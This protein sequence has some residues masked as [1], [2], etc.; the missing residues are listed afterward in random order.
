MRLQWVFSSLA[1]QHGCTVTPDVSDGQ[2]D[3]EE[4]KLASRL[5]ELAKLHLTGIPSHVFVRFSFK[6]SRVLALK[7]FGG[8]VES[9]EEEEMASSEESDLEWE[10]EDE[11]S[12]EED[13]HWAA[14]LAFYKSGNM[15][16]RADKRKRGT[17]SLTEMSKMYRF[18]RGEKEM[19][20]LREYASSGIAP[21]SRTTRLKELSEAFR[22]VVFDMMD[23]GL[24][25]H[26]T[27]LRTL[28]IRENQKQNLVKNFKASSWWVHHWKRRYGVS[29]RKVTKFVTRK[30]KVDKTKQ[31]EI[32]DKF[33]QEIK[34]YMAANPS[35]V[36]L[37]YDQ[38]GVQK[39][40]RSQRT[41]ARK[42]EKKVEVLASSSS[43]LTH[44]HTLMP[45]I[46]HTGGINKTLFVQTAE[47]SGKFPTKMP[48]VPDNIYLTCGTSHIMG[49]KTMEEFFAHV[50]FKDLP[51]EC[52]LLLDSWG[53]FRKH[54]EITKHFPP[55][56]SI[57]IKNIPA[58]ATSR[59]QPLD[60][61]FN[62]QL[63]VVIRR[64]HDH[65]IIAH[66]DTFSVAKRENSMKIFSQIHWAFCHSR[67][68]PNRVFAFYKC[69]YIDICP[70]RS[71]SYTEVLFGEGTKGFC[72]SYACRA[73]GFVMCVYCEKPYCFLCYFQNMHRCC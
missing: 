63:K 49:Y 35:S 15:S 14:A 60:M 30:H 5:D 39:E 52:L 23:H 29:S 68:I 45:G 33:V 51:Q 4:R 59:I 40:L 65:A 25:L 67:F 31:K 64:I 21:K 13:K 26:D 18:I 62:R 10:G 7:L 73:A 37:N 70:P 20:L 48:P 19:R 61:A 12:T 1:K 22:D 71:P 54:S 9:E 17:R 11:E 3:R 55:G 32:E 44:S 8:D 72:S 58:G 47:P 2:L 16:E 69:G 36:V 43:A 56:H 24:P 34:A 66:A 50:A 42:G 41:L 53:C 38:T 28:A 46:D 57:E 6:Q 27:D